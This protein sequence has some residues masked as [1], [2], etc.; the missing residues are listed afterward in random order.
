MSTTSKEICKQLANGI[1]PITRSKLTGARKQMFGKFCKAGLEYDTTCNAFASQP[2]FNPIS[3]RKITKDSEV[4]N[5]LKGMCGITPHAEMGTSISYNHIEEPD[6]SSSKSRG[7]SRGSSARA[8]PSSANAMASA[9]QCALLERKIEAYIEA[10]DEFYTSRAK[11]NRTTKANP[12][13]TKRMVREIEMLISE[14]YDNWVSTGLEP[15]REMIAM[16]E[17]S[18]L[19]AKYKSF[20]YP[21]DFYNNVQ[22]F[23]NHSKKLTV[24]DLDDMF[25]QTRDGI[26]I[27]NVGLVSEVEVARTQRYMFLDAIKEVDVGVKKV[28]SDMKRSERMDAPFV[29]TELSYLQNGTTSD[30]RLTKYSKLVYTS[31]YEAAI[32]RNTLSMDDV[33][34]LLSRCKQVFF[35]I[36]F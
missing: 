22:G 5:F 19:P 24:R 14:A 17:P 27:Y 30:V 16:F 10:I 1:D 25:K 11:N 32:N 23:F 35:D 3:K 28:H 9:S 20:M 2:L 15:V 26:D 7:S 36:K 18:M 29:K 6:M 8:T 31:L 13:E 21:M 12:V 33:N 34:R 4:Y